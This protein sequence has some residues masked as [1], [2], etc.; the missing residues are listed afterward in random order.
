MTPLLL[1]P[2]V[3]SSSLA[4]LNNELYSHYLYTF[5]LD[6]L[7]WLKVKLLSSCQLWRAIQ[8]SSQW[9]WHVDILLCKII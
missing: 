7:C 1:F 4:Y 2:F 6:F 5:A 9:S 3:F 8:H